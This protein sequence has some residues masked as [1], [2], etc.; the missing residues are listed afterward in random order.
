MERKY[1][2]LVIDLNKLRNNFTQIVSR[3]AARGIAVAGVIKGV[4][5]MP[6]IARL[7]RS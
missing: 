4:D 3:C 5:G 6:E 1:P 7:Y 2:R